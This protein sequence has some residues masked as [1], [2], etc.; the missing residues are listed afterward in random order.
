M[1]VAFPRYCGF[2]LL[3]KDILF[4]DWFINGLKQFYGVV[5]GSCGC[6]PQSLSSCS[7]L[8]VVLLLCLVD[9]AWHCNCLS[10]KEGGWLLCFSLV[11]NV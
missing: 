3:I 6:S 7:V 8:F 1:N 5:V 2:A 9:H 4:V 10:R 11:C